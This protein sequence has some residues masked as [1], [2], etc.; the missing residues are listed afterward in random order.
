MT[1]FG[2]REKG[3]ALFAGA[4]LFLAAGIFVGSADAQSVGFKP[5]V[6]QTSKAKPPAPSEEKESAQEKPAPVLPPVQAKI[7]PETLRMLEVI[8]KKNRE[9]KNREERLQVKEQT[10]KNLELKLQ[11][12]LQKI[13]DALAKSREEFGMRRN[14]VDKNLDSLVNVYSAMKPADA[15]NLLGALDEDIAVQIVSRMKSKTAGSVMGKM[16]TL[17]AK[18]ISEKI[19]GKKATRFSAPAPS[20]TK[21]DGAPRR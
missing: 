8:E 10:L 19:A 17:V 12:D 11:A 21:N 1:I 4:V 6:G 20:A 15:A 13:D 16:D 2:F 3:P 14:F 18:K 5:R 7:S 9:L